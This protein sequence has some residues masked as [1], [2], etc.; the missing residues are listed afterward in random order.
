MS[1]GGLSPITPRLRGEQIRGSG[2]SLQQDVVGEG[3]GNVSTGSPVP[4]VSFVWDTDVRYP[5]VMSRRLVNGH[6]QE[7][8]N[9]VNAIL[10][11]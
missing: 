4:Y 9:M 2:T 3:K 10:K 6:L 8:D 1:L 5:S 7:Q 11:T